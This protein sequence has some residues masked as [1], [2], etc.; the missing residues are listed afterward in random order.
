MSVPP[1]GSEWVLECAGS[2]GRSL[3]LGWVSLD[4]W[5]S[6]DQATTHPLREVVQTSRHCLE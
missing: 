4:S 3:P 6:S 2:G 1:R 5:A